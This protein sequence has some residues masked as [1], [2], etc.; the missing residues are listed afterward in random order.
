MHTGTIIAINNSV[1]TVRFTS[2][3]PRLHELLETEGTPPVRLETI[4]AISQTDYH[5]LVLDAAVDLVMGESVHA[6][7]LTLQMPVGKA[8]L[9]RAFNVFGEPIDGKKIGQTEK[10]SLYATT[11]IDFSQVEPPNTIL[12]TGIKAID[13]FSPLLRG[14]KMALVGGAG[15]GKTILLTELINNTII[16]AQKN[17]KKAP[18]KSEREPVA[19]F[20]AV[21]ERSR[22]A[23]ELIESLRDADVL[24][25]TTLVVGQ[26]GENP[27]IRW[28]AAAAGTT[29][30]EYFRDQ[31]QDVLFFMD[32]IYRFAQAGYE[33]STLL[34][35]LPSE[36]GYQPSI[37]S[38]IGELQERLTSTSQA[39]ITSIQALYVPSDDLTDYGVRSIIPHI[40]SI[41]VLSREIYQAGLLPAVNV[42]ESSSAALSPEIAG[43]RHYNLY[44]QSKDILERAKQIERIVSLVGVA[45]LSAE[46][47][48]VYQRSLLL[49]N[50]MTQRFT[51]ASSQTGEP[52]MYIPLATVLADVEKILSGELDAID[53]KQ[54]LYCKRI[55]ATSDSL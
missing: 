18:E 48:T 36:D 32:N 31:G 35:R 11:S 42:L 50:Y 53:P 21:G 30:A 44:L 2:G 43:E 34:N 26:M 5:C 37:P 17:A 19:V 20:S 4:S 3:M 52:G 55:T 51:V 47:R 28:R 12:P 41:V 40:D 9:G 16:R 13:F 22:E 27:A 49:Q 14:G 6:T 46:D 15:V 1:A 7:S 24:Q 29:I 54:L 23:Q 39:S 45:E 25:K 10:R 33:L 38:E 8:I